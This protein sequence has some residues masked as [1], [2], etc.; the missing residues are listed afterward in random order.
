MD[1]IKNQLENNIIIRNDVYILLGLISC[2]FNEHYIC[3]LINLYEDFNSLKKGL[4][5][6]YDDMSI[7]HD[8]NE[9]SNYKDLLED[10]LPYIGIYIKNI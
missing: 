8:L 6:F 5:Y 2:P 4:T 10:N 9:I 3:M 1:K 7:N